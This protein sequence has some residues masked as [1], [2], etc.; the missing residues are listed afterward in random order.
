MAVISSAMNL[1]ISL[2]NEFK[3]SCFELLLCR[4]SKTPFHLDY[5]LQYVEHIPIVV[6]KNSVHFYIQLHAMAEVETHTRY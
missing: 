6:K 1:F 3:V 2:G 5:S 4:D